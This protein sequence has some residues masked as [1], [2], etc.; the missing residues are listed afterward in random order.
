M[1]TTAFGDYTVKQ[2][3]K[4]KKRIMIIIRR[5]IWHYKWKKNPKINRNEW[6]N[7]GWHISGRQAL[8]NKLV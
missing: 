1:L 7:A 2:K 5:V 3:E 8:Y 4:K 6:E